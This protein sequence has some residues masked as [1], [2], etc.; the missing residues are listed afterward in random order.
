MNS[1]RYGFTVLAKSTFSRARV[2]QQRWSSH[3]G[4]LGM[5]CLV[6]VLLFSTLLTAACEE[7]GSTRSDEGPILDPYGADGPVIIDDSGTG[8]P[9]PP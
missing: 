9:T 3:Y 6:G 4:A 1:C 2:E 8:K 7:S 5:N